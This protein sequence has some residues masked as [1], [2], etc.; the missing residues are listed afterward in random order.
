MK[1]IWCT[2]C[3]DLV[4]L[5]R[6]EVRKC[7]CGRIS[8]KYVDRGHAIVSPKAIS[9]VIGNKHLKDSALRMKRLLRRRPVS[10]K[11]AYKRKAAIELA[12]VRPKRGTRKPS[13]AGP[14]KVQN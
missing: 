3:N 5:T 13:N 6:D 7:K 9:V 12:Y 8:G 11:S 14:G 10:S 2:K 1:L 4:K